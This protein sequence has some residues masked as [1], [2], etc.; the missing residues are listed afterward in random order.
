M[1]VSL[2]ADRHEYSNT[3]LLKRSPPRV[4]TTVRPARRP[5]KPGGKRTANRFAKFAE[6]TPPPKATS[7]PLSMTTPDASDGLIAGMSAVAVDEAHHVVEIP[8]SEVAPH[9]FNDNARSRP[10]LAIPKGTELVDGVRANGVRL[11][12]L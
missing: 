1:P 11:P 8:V 9:P 3:G 5:A 4:K 7:P 6:E 12:V 2:P 10:S